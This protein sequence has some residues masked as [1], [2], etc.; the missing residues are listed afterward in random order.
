MTTTR[1]QRKHFSAQRHN[2]SVRKEKKLSCFRPFSTAVKKNKFRKYNIIPLSTWH[3]CDTNSYRG[4]IFLFIS[5]QMKL[6][7]YAFYPR[8]NTRFWKP[9]RTKLKEKKKIFPI[10]SFAQRGSRVPVAIVRRSL[11]SAGDRRVKQYANERNAIE[12][13]D[14]GKSTNVL[15][16]LIGHF[17]F[18]ASSFG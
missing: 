17:L 5:H 15:S 16:L 7:N 9:H 4:G 2:S 12:F 13:S 1:T 8:N 14:F 6:H 10:R 3:Q 18:M 11:G